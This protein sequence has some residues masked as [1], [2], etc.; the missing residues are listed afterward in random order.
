MINKGNKQSST[1]FRT[2]EEKL[3]IWLQSKEI[4]RQLP[5][6]CPVVATYDPDGE[7][8]C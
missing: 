8:P 1:L 3:G 6:Q 2:N 7:F 5:K 4:Q